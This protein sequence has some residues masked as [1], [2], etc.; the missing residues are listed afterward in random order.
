MQHLAFSGLRS[1]LSRFLQ[2][3]TDIRSE[4]PNDAYPKRYPSSKNNKIEK[5]Y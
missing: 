5:R 3:A 2:R 4:K 1:V